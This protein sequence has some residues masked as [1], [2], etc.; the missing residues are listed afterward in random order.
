MISIESLLLTIFLG[1]M[2]MSPCFFLLTPGWSSS[3][4]MGSIVG[5]LEMP[6]ETGEAGG[7]TTD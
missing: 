6:G 7:L 1:L 3:S 4:L 5:G 2:V